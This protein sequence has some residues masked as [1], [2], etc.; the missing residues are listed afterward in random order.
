MVIRQG[1]CYKNKTSGKI[2]TCDCIAVMS[3]FEKSINLVIIHE[4][5]YYR[6]G[7]IAVAACDFRKEFTEVEKPVSDDEGQAV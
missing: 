3:F 5:N 7:Q 2:Y 4:T 6:R 1:G